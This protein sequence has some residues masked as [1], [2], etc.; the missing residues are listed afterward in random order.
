MRFRG[1][2]SDLAVVVQNEIV[3]G[4]MFQESGMSASSASR[5]FPRIHWRYGGNERFVAALNLETPR[6]YRA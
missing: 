3:S 1:R 4:E 2:R 5:S 6:F